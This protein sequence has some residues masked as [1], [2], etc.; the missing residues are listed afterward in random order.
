MTTPT[1]SG[2]GALSRRTDTGPAQKLRSL[3]D[4]EYGEGAT[5]KDLQRGA[6]LGQSSPEV[7][8]GGLMG[9]GAAERVIPMDAPSSDPG[10][11]VTT[12]AA[13]GDGGGPE[14]LGIEPQR[15]QDLRS[16]AKYLPVLEFMANQHGAPWGVRNLVRKIKAAL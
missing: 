6:A 14:I 4:A 10:E 15:D 13:A 12:G 1:V 7:P 8:P 5:Y 3:P 16:Q 2:P 11:P 9:N